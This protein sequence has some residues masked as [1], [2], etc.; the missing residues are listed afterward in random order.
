M[1]AGLEDQLISKRA[2][3]IRTNPLHQR[4]F[5]SGTFLSFLQSAKID[6][7]GLISSRLFSSL[8]N[9]GLCI[10]FW[11]QF[12]SLLSTPFQS[13][14]MHTWWLEWVSFMRYF[15]SSRFSLFWK[16]NSANESWAFLS[17]QLS[18]FK[19]SFS[20]TFLE[21]FSLLSISRTTIFSY[22]WLFILYS[23]FQCLYSFT[24]A[25]YPQEKWNIICTLFFFY[26]LWWYCCLFWRMTA[27]SDPSICLFL[28]STFSFFFSLLYSLKEYSSFSLINNTYWTIKSR[29]NIWWEKWQFPSHF[30]FS[31]A[32]QDWLF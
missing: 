18:F 3:F 12:P 8:L 10:Y 30:C 24:L 21:S 2:D 4:P 26:T 5:K 19:I 20:L 17:Y 16:F 32:I 28:S 29:E 25:P 31:S 9:Y 11:S 23:L 15:V 1:L 14:T 27:I 7:L 6:N 13:L 22:I